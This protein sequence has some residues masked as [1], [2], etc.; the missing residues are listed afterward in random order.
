MDQ[1]PPLESA[2]TRERHIKSLAKLQSMFHSFSL[3]EKVIFLIASALFAFGAFSLVYKI[4]QHFMVNVP[5]HGGSLTEGILGTPRFVNPLLASS[6]SSRPSL[7]A[8][9]HQT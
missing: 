7:K 3:T 5:A 9:L 4:S 2:L 6:D 1:N 8:V